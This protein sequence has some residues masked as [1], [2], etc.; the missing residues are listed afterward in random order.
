[1]KIKINPKNKG[2]VLMEFVFCVPLIVVIFLA[3]FMLGN[4][5]CDQQRLLTADR[6]VTWRHLHNNQA[7]IDAN[8]RAYYEFGEPNEQAQRQMFMN[9]YMLRN[10]VSLAGN[11]LYKVLKP[12]FFAHNIVDNLRSTHL[13]SPNETLDKL[14]DAT[15]KENENAGK[16]C[17]RIVEYWPKGTCYR[18][19]ADFAKAG[20]LAR[21]LGH[22]ARGHQAKVNNQQIIFRRRSA[23]DGLLWRRG[24]SSYREIIRDEFL[25]EFHNAVESV[26]IPS[27]K[28][29][30]K[31]LYLERW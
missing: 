21:R 28:N 25:Q 5:M 19:T 2:T 3:I 18:I 23:R 12:N 4:L 24:Q 22:Q 6:Y 13:A 8:N 20:S 27:L 17:A 26:S 11:E 10:Y 15:Q 29:S 7:R 9:Q 16:L 1:M 14:T 30:L 31:S